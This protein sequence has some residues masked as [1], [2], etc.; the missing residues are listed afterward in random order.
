MRAL[1]PTR[2]QFALG[3]WFS[4]WVRG[5]LV[6]L[7]DPLPFALKAVAAVDARRWLARVISVDGDLRRPS[8]PG[9]TVHGPVTR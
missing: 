7:D 9:G 6:A 2:V 5:V 3:S 1:A 4:I 8:L